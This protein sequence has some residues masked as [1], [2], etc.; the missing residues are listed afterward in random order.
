MNVRYSKY[1]TPL[2]IGWDILLVSTILFYILGC[3]DSN[4]LLSHIRQL[5]VWELWALC[6]FCWF[7]IAD[8]TRIYS[9]LRGLDIASILRRFVTQTTFFGVIILIIS[10]IINISFT[11]HY[12]SL[13]ILG[14]SFLLVLAPRLLFVFV[15]RKHRLQGGNFRNVVF[16]DE[17]DNTHNLINLFKKNKLYGMSV[18]GVFTEN[19]SSPVHTHLYNRND[20]D[21]F[22]RQKNV[23]TIFF[24]LSGPIENKIQEINEI[25]NKN[26]LQVVYVPRSEFDFAS[27][28]RMDFF[29]GFPVLATQ[30]LPLDHIGNRILKRL[31]DIV[32]SSAV[33]VF[34]L[35]WLYPILALLIKL[36]SKGEVIFVQQRNALNGKPFGCYKFR[37]MRP[38]SDAGIAHTVKGDKRITRIGAFLRK[39]SLDEFPQFVN[40]LKG[41]MSIVGPRP[42]MVSQDTYYNS[43]LPKYC[44]RYY[45]KP[46]ITGLSQVSG[47]RG[48]ITTD[49]D[50]KNRVITD[51]FYVRKWSFLMDLIIIAKTAY[52]LVVGDQKA[53]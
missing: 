42:H 43:F 38:S 33:I 45:V 28:V 29:F 52:K 7:F 17:N 39:T 1:V 12:H 13:G 6:I 3:S 41:D 50:M 25:V 37:T 32:L 21:E 35:S 31:F 53:I 2:C 9:L 10:D 27:G 19:P 49:E 4:V 34:I 40:V 51:M 14:I 47:Y 44:I 23:S 11:N 24:S 26:R 16:I 36:N 8:K 18:A 30:R 5:W 20:L 46:G 15:L 48:E 22:I